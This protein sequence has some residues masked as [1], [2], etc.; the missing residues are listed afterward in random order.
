MFCISRILQL[1]YAGVD[2]E[3][4]STYMPD[5]AE[6][7]YDIDQRIGKWANP[8]PLLPED[9]FLCSF[10]HIFAGWLVILVPCRLLPM[11]N[12]LL[13][14]SNL[15]MLNLQMIMQLAITVISGQR[16]YPQMLIQH[17][18]RPG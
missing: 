5:K 12:G 4:Y 1:R 15:S 10:S 7:I 18:R 17:L 16:Y 9:R 6:S 13:S 3:L 14:L 2:L 11:G 8:M